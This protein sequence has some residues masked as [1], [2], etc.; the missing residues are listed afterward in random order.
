MISK[1][2]QQQQLLEE[3]RHSFNK[4]T[5]TSE[6][7]VSQEQED[8]RTTQMETFKSKVDEVSK[9]PVDQSG[10]CKNK[11]VVAPKDHAIE[12]DIKPEK[13]YVVMIWGSND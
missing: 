13:R 2:I 7:T 6:D 11:D 10:D 12:T 3:T 8:L 1:Q 4:F 5:K 9:L